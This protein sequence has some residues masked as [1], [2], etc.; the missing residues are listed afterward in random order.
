MEWEGECGAGQLFLIV[1][2][3]ERGV[4]VAGL[5]FVSEKNA[6]RGGVRGAIIQFFFFQRQVSRKVEMKRKT[7]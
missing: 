4:L 6:A 7:K 1:E 3:G 2:K 5:L